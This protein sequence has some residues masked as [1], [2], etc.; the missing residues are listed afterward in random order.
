MNVNG[1]CHPTLSQHKCIFGQLQKMCLIIPTISP[2]Y[3]VYRFQK[4]FHF[5]RNEETNKILPAEFKPVKQEVEKIVLHVLSLSSSYVSHLSLIYCRL[6][7]VS[8]SLQFP[9]KV[10]KLLI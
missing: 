2:T 4:T 5:R 6:W 9:D 3:M 7:Q 1:I 8:Y 10:L